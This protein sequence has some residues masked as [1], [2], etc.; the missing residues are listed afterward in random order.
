[1]SWTC[2]DGG[3]IDYA[4]GEWPKLPRQNGWLAWAKRGAAPRSRGGW[5]CHSQQGG[6]WQQGRSQSCSRSGW[7]AD[8]RGGS[9]QRSG[10]RW[11]KES[12]ASSDAVRKA[13]DKIVH[14]TGV[15]A[16]AE[17]RRD[18]LKDAL[19]ALLLKVAAADAEVEARKSALK[20]AELEAEAARAEAAP[21]DNGIEVDELSAAARTASAQS[22]TPEVRALLKALLDG[23]ADAA[24]AA[25]QPDADMDA[26]G[27]AVTPESSASPS[28]ALAAASLLPADQ[29]AEHPKRAAVVEVAPQVPPKRLKADEQNG[30]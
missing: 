20:E 23:M 18:G 12:W 17:A 2:H 13:E 27:M 9:S 26:A 5:D 8:G 10:G 29:G 6:G 15:V 4:R 19:A 16:R 7:D 11:S 22:L 24:L 14:R 28:L 21:A 1:M 25:T 3:W 30:G